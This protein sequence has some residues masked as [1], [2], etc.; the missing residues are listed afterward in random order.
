[1]VSQ[2]SLILFQPALRYF[3][4]LSLNFFAIPTQR[5]IQQAVFRSIAYHSRTIRLPVHVHNLLNRARRV[6][7]TLKQELGRTPTNDEMAEQLDMTPEKFAKILNLTKRTISLEKPKYAN[8]P[9]DLG[10]AS[11]ATLGD[12]LDSSS[13]IKDES[14]PEEAVDQS[15]FQDDLKGMLKVS[16]GIYF[17]N[18][19]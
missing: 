9:K 7:T 1:M 3:D 5:W 13:T 8:N 4:W 18:M 11:D 2:L 10:H 16:C 6:K 12:S 17:I 14:S 15:L 19:I